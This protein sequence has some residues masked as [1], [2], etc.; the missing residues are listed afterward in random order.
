MKLTIHLLD[1]N[2]SENTE[3]KK[4]TEENQ[5]LHLQYRMLDPYSQILPGGSPHPALFYPT[6]TPGTYIVHLGR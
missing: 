5:Y 4:E 6:I 1:T 2:E 3:E